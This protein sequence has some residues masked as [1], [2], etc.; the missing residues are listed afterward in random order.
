MKNI[1]LLSLLILVVLESIGQTSKIVVLLNEKTIGKNLV[2]QKEIKA[3]EY[4]FPKRIYDSHVDSTLGYAT[5]QLRK[6][7]KNGKVLDITGIIAVYDLTN[8]TVKWSKKIDY[9]RENLNQYNSFIF[10][11]KG[12]KTISLNIENGEEI[13]DVKNYFY[14]VNPNKKIGVGYKHKGLVGDNHTLE[15][16]NL[17]NGTTIWEKELNNDYGWN[18]ISQLNDSTLLISAAGLHQLNLKNGQGW[19]YNTITGKKD[20]TETVA[21]NVAGIALGVLTGT[22]IISSG[23]NLVKDVLSNEITENN[24]IYLASKEQIVKLN[25]LNGTVFWSQ[26]LSKD[27]TSKSSI[28]IKDSL[29]YMINKGYAYWGNKRIDFGA[30]FIA[31]YNKEN[32]EPYFFTS[33][34]EK[35]NPILDFKLVKNKLV[36]IFKDKITINSLDNG[37]ELFSK[38]FIVDELGELR[39]FI[40]DRLYKNRND[41]E[42]SNLVA[43]DTSKYFVQTNKSKSLELDDAFNITNQYD[44]NQLYF[45]YLTYQDYKF[46]VKG[47]QTIMIDKEGKKIAELDVSE[48][49]YIVGNKLYDVNDSRFLEID[50]LEIINN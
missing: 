41:F 4:V 30:P 16:I 45:H 35:K 46:L 1:L 28:F 5:F 44:S 50:L 7:S 29:L 27:L 42:L 32:G 8:K 26:N 36:L 9:S 19:D 31:A 43:S 22:A 15:G 33:I 23:N 34:D 24:N 49:A 20:Y 11:T 37:A 21:K 25:K 12:N 38:P 18:K 14:Y 2:L 47:N 13:W 6:L 39:F 10:Q 3:N 17:A 48:N 40:G